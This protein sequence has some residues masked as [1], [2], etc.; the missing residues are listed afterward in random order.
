MSLKLIN[1]GELV[2]YNSESESMVVFKDTQLAIDDGKIAHP[3]E[4]SYEI[5]YGE[6]VDLG[7]CRPITFHRHEGNLKVIDKQG[8]LVAEVS[9]EEPT[10]FTDE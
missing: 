6:A 5:T 9:G 8:A 1:I 2:T 4:G 10:K 3:M 7:Y